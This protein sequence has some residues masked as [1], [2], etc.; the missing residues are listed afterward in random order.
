M[1][2]NSDRLLERLKYRVTLDM[3]TGYLKGDE[4]TA[5]QLLSPESRQQI[6][7]EIYIVQPGV[8][9]ENRRADLSELLAAA[10]YY[11]AQG[12][13]DVFGIIGS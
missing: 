13:V 5:G 10:R 7:F 2:V 6:Q 1:W 12:G 11:L 3:V 4:D 8:M 9:K